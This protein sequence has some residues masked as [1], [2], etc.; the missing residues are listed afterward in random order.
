MA[1]LNAI[2]ILGTILGFLT[3]P[4]SKVIDKLIPD[5]NKAKEMKHEI[6]KALMTIPFEQY[7]LF[8]QRVAAEMANPNFLRDAVR[9]VITYCAWGTY[10]YI[11][12]TVIYVLSKTYVPAML[13]VEPTIENLPVIKDMA[14][15][16]VTS[17]F[18][19]ADFYIIMGILAFWFGPKAFERVVDKF[20]NTGGIKSIFL[21]NKG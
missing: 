19:T 14:S 13:E 2:P 20:A 12:G 15:E 21:G 16:F 6:E 5:V 7:K 9:P 10:M 1:I 4:I 3:E 18:T 17:M 11:K 8:E